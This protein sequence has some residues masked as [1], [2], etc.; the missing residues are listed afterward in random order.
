[1]YHSDN[2]W[3][4]LIGSFKLLQ[5]ALMIAIGITVLKFVHRDIIAHLHRWIM[6]LGFDPDSSYVDA[7]L[8]RAANLTPTKVKLL[9]AGSF[10][11]AVLFLTEGTGLLLARRWAEWFTVIITSSLLPVEVY[12]LIRHPSVIKVAILLI[13][14]VA[15]AYLLH[16]I[17]SERAQR[18]SLPSAA[19][20]D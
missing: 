16:R 18:S 15:V 4:R 11:Y 20:A 17:R 1:M 12:S 6:L 3:V 19:I 10:L 5:A 13:N 9:G 2:R 8:Q 14:L 7:A